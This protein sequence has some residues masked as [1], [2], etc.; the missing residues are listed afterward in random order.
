MAGMGGVLPGGNPGLQWGGS[1]TP[2][3]QTAWEADGFLLLRALL[4]RE[5]VELLRD[6]ARAQVAAGTQPATSEH[7]IKGT[8]PG[9][10]DRD[11]SGQDTRY[12]L[13]NRTGTLTINRMKVPASYSHPR[14]AIGAAPNLTAPPSIRTSLRQAP[15]AQTRRTPSAAPSA[16]SASRARSPGSGAASGRCSTTTN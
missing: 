4:P 9:G 10:N 2:E 11:E 8:A 16:R 3:M 14:G 1:L 7:Y 13:T 6:L 12:W 5:D 15:P